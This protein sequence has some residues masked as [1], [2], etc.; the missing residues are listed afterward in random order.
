MPAPVI[1]WI[2]AEWIAARIAGEGRAP[3]PQIDL[4]PIVADAQ[5]R[6]VAYT[7]LVPAGPLPPAGG[8]Q[9]PRVG[10]IEHLLDPGVDRADA[11]AS[12]RAPRTGQA[13][14]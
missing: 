9:P 2:V 1:D 3:V 6:V 12:H 10:G 11:R 8:R 4:A 14:G 5:E 13:R 7:G